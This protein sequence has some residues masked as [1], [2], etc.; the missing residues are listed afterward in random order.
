MA[1][2]GC[3]PTEP[4][5]VETIQLGRGLNP[6]NSVSGHT[7]SFKPLDTM[8]VSVLTPEKGRGKIGVRWTYEGRVVAEA[9]PDPV[10]VSSRDVT[11]ARPAARSTSR[12]TASCAAS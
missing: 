3:G 9:M 2:A 12:G 6:D 5:R 7:S 4:L 8:Y 11:S 1:A 10:A